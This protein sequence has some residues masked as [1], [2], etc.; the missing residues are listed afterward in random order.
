MSVKRGQNLEPK[1]ANNN[2]NNNNNNIFD[3]VE[4]LRAC[5]TSNVYVFP[6]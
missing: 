2:G 4:E 3:S 6:R 1:S 5:F